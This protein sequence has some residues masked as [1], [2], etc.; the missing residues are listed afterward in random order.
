MPLGARLLGK[1]TAVRTLRLSL[2]LALI[3]TLA[4]PAGAGATS[5]SGGALPDLTWSSY[6]YIAACDFTLLDVTVLNNGDAEAGP[7]AIGYQIDHLRVGSAHN[8][9]PVAP[10]ETVPVGPFP[11]H[12][13]TKGAHLVTFHMDSRHQVE[14][15]DEANNWVAFAFICY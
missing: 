6:S 5:S 11:S 10:G 13:V 7:F 3:L 8:D 14:E 2:G 1:E 4:L 12:H 9:Q 15:S